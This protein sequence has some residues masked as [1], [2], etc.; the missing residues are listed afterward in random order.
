M[1]AQLCAT[2]HQPHP[3]WGWA[4]Q[5]QGQPGCPQLAPCSPSCLDLLLGG[6]AEEYPVMALDVETPEEADARRT[7][8]GPHSPSLPSPDCPAATLSTLEFRQLCGVGHQLPTVP[9]SHHVLPCPLLLCETLVIALQ[10]CR[11]LLLDSDRTA[12]KENCRA[13]SEETL[14]GREILVPCS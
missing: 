6:G 3:G 8:C 14:G 10:M 4:S 7:K 11:R 9:A 2:M 5:C 13:S 1:L 12:P